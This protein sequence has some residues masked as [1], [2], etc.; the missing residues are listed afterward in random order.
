MK[1]KKPICRYPIDI[2]RTLLI[3]GRPDAQE[4]APGIVVDRV[5]KSFEQH[6]EKWEFNLT[7]EHNNKEI[8]ICMTNPYK[9]PET[10]ALQHMVFLHVV[11]LE[12][13]RYGKQKN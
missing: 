11:Y 8:T 9:N 5:R 12:Y 13:I 3:L 1:S 7:I 6:Q 4:I 2:N 10:R